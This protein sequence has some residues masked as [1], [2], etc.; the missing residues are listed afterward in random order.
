MR[1][2]KNVG[3]NSEMSDPGSRLP[4]F[5]TV[6][7]LGDHFTQTSPLSLYPAEETEARAVA[8]TQLVSGRC[9]SGVSP[10][11]GRVSPLTLPPLLNARAGRPT[12]CPVADIACQSW[13]MTQNIPQYGNDMLEVE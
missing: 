8:L 2:V 13:H 3:G 1:I 9:A 11:D 7:S 4:C 12:H 5:L 10:P 6:S